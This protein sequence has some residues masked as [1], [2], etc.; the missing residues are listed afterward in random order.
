LLTLLSKY[1]IYWSNSGDGFDWADAADPKQPIVGAN[2][3]P[4]GYG[5]HGDFCPYKAIFQLPSN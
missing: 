4:T 1:E 2:G 3:D 5:L